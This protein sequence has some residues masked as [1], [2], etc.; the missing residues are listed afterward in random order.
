[1][2]L[3]H[4][5]QD[6]DGLLAVIALVVRLVEIIGLVDEQHAAH[7]LLEDFA[8]FRRGVADI[9][10]DEVVA[11]P[12]RCPLRTYIM[13]P[14][15]LAHGRDARWRSARKSAL[16]APT[17]GAG[18]EPRCGPPHRATAAARPAPH[19]AAATP[20]ETSPPRRHPQDPARPAAAQTR[21]PAHS[22]PQTTSRT[23]PDRLSRTAPYPLIIA[24]PSNLSRAHES[25][26]TARRQ[27]GPPRVTAR[28]AA[29]QPRSAASAA[30]SK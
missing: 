11:S 9:L 3:H 16:P 15:V 8:G 12:T 29:S 18:A 21:A 24:K 5:Q 10:A 27:E 17:H 23:A 2:V 22:S 25:L 26:S 1:M 13:L 14:A 30:R 20:P 7:G 19:P 28:R 6:F 4:L